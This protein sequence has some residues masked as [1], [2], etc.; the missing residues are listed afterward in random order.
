MH[1]ADVFATTPA[2]YLTGIGTPILAVLIG[3][4]WTRTANRLAS[5]DRAMIEQSKALAVI[6]AETTSIAATAAAAKDKADTLAITTAVLKESVDTHHR[7]A[8][9]WS[10]QHHG[11]QAP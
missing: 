8:E 1:M 9:R 3:A 7:W 4:M 6:V 2:G 5:Q 10:E 11:Q